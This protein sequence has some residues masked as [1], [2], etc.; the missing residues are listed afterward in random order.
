[1]IGHGTGVLADQV[2][3]VLGRTGLQALLPLLDKFELHVNIADA[4]RQSGASADASRHYAQALQLL[5]RQLRLDPRELALQAHY[6]SHSALQQ[7]SS[8]M[9]SALTQDSKNA[10]IWLLD[11]MLQ[12][13]LG[14]PA[15]G[16]TSVRQAL[17]YG[18]P[19][20]LLAVEPDLA[21]LSTKTEFQKLINPTTGR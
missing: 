2:G 11:A 1:M 7:A 10:E 14:Q 21:T 15:A 18:F 17:Q 16:M 6:L 19:A 4:Y 8:V 20:K 3:L 12:V 9:A 5:S 13:R